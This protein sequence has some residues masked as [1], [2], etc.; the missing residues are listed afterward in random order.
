MRNFIKQWKDVDEL[1]DLL[2][3]KNIQ[4]YIVGGFV[5]SYIE[6]TLPRDIDIIV[7]CDISILD[8]LVI[9]QG[10]KHTRNLFGSYKLKLS[11]ETDIWTMENQYSD[12]HHNIKLRDTLFYNYDSIIYDVNHNTIDRYYYDKCMSECMLDFVGTQDIINV[13][14]PSYVVNLN[15]V[16]AYSISYERG[17]SL[18]KSIITYLKEKNIAISILQKE[19]KRHYHREMDKNLLSYI[20]DYIKHNK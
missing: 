3:V 6:N 5:R 2:L 8:S 11:L 9:S 10:Y 17:L 14:N 12:I 16:K 7:D 1:I 20:S 18:S 15:L 4:V 19:Y 13:K